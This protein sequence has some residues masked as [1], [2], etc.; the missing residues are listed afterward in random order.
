MMS[1]TIWCWHTLLSAT[2]QIL[3]LLARGHSFCDTGGKATINPA[4]VSVFANGNLQSGRVGTD[5][6]VLSS[7]GVRFISM[8]LRP[9]NR[10]LTFPCCDDP[11][12][13]GSSRP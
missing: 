12:C 5:L 3:S 10:L 2:L 11:V 4:G 8:R 13:L 7:Y 6:P 1:N 9:C